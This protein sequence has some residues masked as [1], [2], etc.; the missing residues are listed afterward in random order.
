MKKQTEYVRGRADGLELA[1]RIVKEGGVE[2]LEEEIRFRGAL[3]IHT[4]IAR[5]EF[6]VAAEEIKKLTIETMMVAWVSILHD[7][8]GFGRIRCDRALESF[9][10]LTG[11]LDRGWLYWMD[12]VAEIKQRLGVRLQLERITPENLGQAYAHPEPDDI[13]TEAD[14]LLP[15][16]WQSALNLLHF[17]ERPRDDGWME[18]LDEEGKPIINYRGVYNQIQVYD[19]L[20]GML[21]ACDHWGIEPKEPALVPK[22]AKPVQARKKKRKHR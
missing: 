21:L 12:L 4:S 19:V 18:I 16:A 1:L 20:H 5:R 2:S 14:L 13:Y 9:R 7:E 3:G 22:P 17:T 10:K 8:F 15:E 6:E 11:Y